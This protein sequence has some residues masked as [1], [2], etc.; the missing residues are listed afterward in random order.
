MFVRFCQDFYPQG[1]NATKI[2]RR[3]CRNKLGA[4]M[5]KNFTLIE[6]LVVIAIIA[7]LAAMLLPALQQARA[8]ATSTKC[9]NNLKQ[10]GN[11]AA[12]YFGDHRDWWPE[13]SRNLTKTVTEADGT[14]LE[15]RNYVWNFYRG[16]YIGIGPANQTDSGFLLC[17][18]M[19]L[20]PN[21]PSNGRRYPQ[22]Y[23]TQYNHNA[24]NSTGYTA[25]G[26]G[27][28]ISNPGWNDGAVTYADRSKATGH[29]KIGN[30]QRVLLIDN[31]SKI[32]GAK[33]GAAVAHL[34]AFGN[35]VGDQ[36]VNFGQP[37]FLHGG[38]TNLLTVTGNVAS[39]GVDE[40]LA[41]YYH[42]WFGKTVPSSVR[43]RGYYA[44]GP[45]HL[46]AQGN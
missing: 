8:R 6:L 12:T 37:Y 1:K 34:F 35:A 41:E 46:Y 17:S 44:D 43:G 45:T 4:K 11:V 38:R 28:Q 21:D 40:Y 32:D 16:K 29:E 5:R 14:V 33:G 25:G 24:T 36:S 10:L 31:I 23:G 42:P 9:I 22:V 7:I 20:K 26:I 3:E 39:V 13:A 19:Q 2:N 15:C 18:S 30:S 27:Y